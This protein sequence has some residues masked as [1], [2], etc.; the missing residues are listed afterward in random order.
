[1]SNVAGAKALTTPMAAIAD[2]PTITA[3]ASIMAEQ[4]IC[5]SANQKTVLELLSNIHWIQKLVCDNRA[6]HCAIR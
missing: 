4:K 6:V 5:H 3:D 2:D 1:M